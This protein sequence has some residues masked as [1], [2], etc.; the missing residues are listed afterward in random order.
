MKVYGSDICKDCVAA[1][2][3]LLNK[4][5]CYT[6]VDMTANTTN[7]KEFLKLRDSRPEFDPIKEKGSI[8]IPCFVEGDIIWFDSLDNKPAD[9]VL[10]QLVDN[11]ILRKDEAG[12]KI[13]EITFPLAGEGI[14]EI[15]HTFVDDSLRGQ[16]VAAKL[17]E[18]A[19]EQIHEKGGKVTASCSYAAH[20]MEKNGITE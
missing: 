18:M 8:G 13:A 10:Y 4:Q 11:S 17:V 15:N 12:N 14:Y 1:K 19:I 2:A 3:D 6:F 7:M 9:I 5:V 20:Y 16:G